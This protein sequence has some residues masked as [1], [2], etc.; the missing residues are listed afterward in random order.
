M[1]DTDTIRFEAWPDPEVEAYGFHAR[2]PYV[3]FCYAPLIGPTTLLTLRAVAAM[4]EA[5]GGPVTV[6]LAEFAK[7]LG[8]SAGTGRNSVI[9][10]T[11]TRLESFGLAVAVPGGYAVRQVVPPLSRRRVDQSPPSVQRIHQHLTAQPRS[12]QRQ[13]G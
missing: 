1:T 11:L 12:P 5:A 7:S 3:E 2:S 10:R 13:A 4:V 6:E 8:V 9:R